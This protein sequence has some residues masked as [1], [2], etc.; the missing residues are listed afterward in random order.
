MPIP[1]YGPSGTTPSAYTERARVINAAISWAKRIAAD[2]S[3]Q[4]VMGAS[5]SQTQDGPNYDCTSF[6]SWAYKNAGVPLTVSSTYDMKGNF[7][8][9]GFKSIPFT[10]N[11]Q[12]YAGDILFYHYSQDSAHA[13]MCTSSTQIVHAAGRRAGILEASFYGTNWQWVLR[14]KGDLAGGGA[15]SIGDSTDF[16]IGGGFIDTPDGVIPGPGSTTGL[17]VYSDVISHSNDR[18][19][20][21]IREIGYYSINDNK[22]STEETGITISAINY[23]TLLGN[24]YDQFAAYY[25][26]GYAVNSD[27]VMPT[28][29]KI[30]F[31]YFASVG[32]SAAASAGIA[33]A[34][35]TLS[36]LEP[37]RPGGICAWE[38]RYRQDMHKAVEDWSTNLTGQ[39]KFLWV[40]LNS[41]KYDILLKLLNNF[42]ISVNGAKQA[43]RRFIVS[44]QAIETAETVDTELERADNA[45]SNAAH[46]FEQLSITALDPMGQPTASSAPTVVTIPI[47]DENED[48][49][50]DITPSP[51]PT[52]TPLPLPSDV[53]DATTNAHSIYTYLRTVTG[54]SKAQACGIVANIQH[55]S[56][57]N[58]TALGDNGTSYGICQWHSG[59]WENLKTWCTT[60]G[61]DWRGLGGQILYLEHD[62]IDNHPDL[63]RKICNQPD[64]AEGAYQ[65]G[66]WWCYDFE[67]PANRDYNARKRGNAAKQY[68][69]D[70]SYT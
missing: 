44:Y 4:Y 57:F 30:A 56:G 59:R 53:G 24:L 20:M 26:T 41:G 39:L 3:H 68:Y 36:W 32:M 15:E 60:R 6:V 22:F 65:S 29:M 46:C 66:Y 62:L 33:G 13:I 31:D 17:T 52:P 43:G 54:L 8:A 16:P 38:G 49:S 70:T 50:G 11:M 63:Y 10:A 37:E 2:D 19:D 5:H 23:T 69:S 42:P 48:G 40:D 21:T 61:Y 55:E 35:M 47:G 14:Y 51:V 28:K 67:I 7:E 12:L 25:P 45:E 18:H 64:T 27:R 1:S 9:A 58:P 34:L